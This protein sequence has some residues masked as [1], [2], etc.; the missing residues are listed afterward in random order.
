[1]NENPEW[2]ELETLMASN[3]SAR[4]AAMGLSLAD[5]EAL[6]RLRFL[7]PFEDPR[8]T[9]SDMGN[10]NLFADFTRGCL[11]YAAQR[12]CWYHYNGARWQEDTGALMAASLAKKLVVLLDKLSRELESS[13]QQKNAWKR[14]AQLYKLRAREEMVRDARTV[15]PISMDQF[16]ADPWLFNCLNGTLDLRRR[17][18]KPHSAD[19]LLTHLAPVHYDPA[20][21]CP[22]FESFVLQIMSQVSQTQLTMEDQPDPSAQKLAYL[23]KSLGYALTGDTSH[24]CMFMLYG[25]TTRNGKSTLLET[26][27]AMMGSYAASINPETLA[28]RHRDGGAPNEDVARLIGKRLV[29]AAE[30]E[31]ALQFNA[32]LIKRLTGNDTITA[33]KLHENSFQFRPQFKLFM[34]TN[35]RP[36]VS[37]RT[38]FDSGRMKVISFERHF[39]P[40]E[41]DPTLKHTF[42]QPENLSAVLNWCLDG[43][44]ML[45]KEGLREPEAIKEAVE[46]YKTDSDWMTLF[47]QDCLLP[48][49]KARVRMKQVYAAYAEWCRQNGFAQ[50]N[51]VVFRRML[52]ERKSVRK[53][54]PDTNENALLVLEHYRL[55]AER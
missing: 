3:P 52:G 6:E 4:A 12:K 11:R 53:M 18:L 54:R 25:A 33:R 49:D 15:N 32:S 51:S 39:A 46:E 10:S 13:E 48:D 24:E 37:E 55:K 5:M 27:S 22:R 17:V 30:P 1:M 44:D 20:A 29:I 45:M 21:R 2:K 42:V 14:I 31:N 34:N 9:I 7:R 43:L 36:Y 47:M 35:H 40:H 8:Y 38:L 26:V 16:D 41:Q 50:V 28:A 19:D 23:Q